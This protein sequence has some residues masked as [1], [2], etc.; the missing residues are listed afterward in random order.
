MRLSARGKLRLQ[1][2]SSLLFA[3][4]WATLGIARVRDDGIHHDEHDLF[5]GV[6]Y[7]LFALG[8]VIWACVYSYRVGRQSAAQHDDTG[9]LR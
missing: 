8:H 4:A 9:K 1:T 2:A 7:F 6:V 3:I 5:F